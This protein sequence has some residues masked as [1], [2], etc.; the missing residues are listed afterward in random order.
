MTLALTPVPVTDAAAPA[1]ARELAA[2]V[3]ARG[4]GNTP[5]HILERARA[6]LLYGLG[7]ATLTAREPY[8]AIAEAA[9][10]AGEPA[11][12]GVCGATVWR[13]G[14][15]HG[16]S[17]AA[18]CNTVLM[19]SRCQEDTSGSAHIG[20]VVI[21]VALALIEAGFARLEDLLPA[22]VAGYEASGAVQRAIGRA[23]TARGF[24]ASPLYGTLAGAA[25]AARLLGLDIDGT[26]AAL[27]NAAAFAGG[28]LQSIGDGTDEWRY[29]MAGATRRALEAAFLARA[30]SRASP[31]SL[32]GA[33]G[34]A[35]AFAD[36]PL[37]APLRPGAPWVLP[38]V[39]FKPYPVCN[40]NQTA[41]LLAARLHRTVDLARV[42]RVHMRINGFVERGMLERG[43]FTSVAGTLMSTYF[44]CAAALVHGTVTRPML[45]RF[46]DPLIARWIG[47][48]EITPDDGVP[49]PSAQA[50]VEFDDGSTRRFD[51]RKVFADYALPRAEVQR[52]L[53]RL[54][55]EQ[56][57]PADG[58]GVSAIAAFADDPSPETMRR[59]LAALADAP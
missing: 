17:V 11:A 22:L 20:I 57:P 35:A 19:H 16:V 50:T 23:S 14:R 37:P 25:T 24:R 7:I 18:A 56:E 46:D 36:M 28:T 3:A 10:C 59:A 58:A 21:P 27:A 26:E 43:G 12:T 48:L 51:E 41:T 38:E 44:A 6:C 49:Y 53:E 30:G 55:R 39:A 1:A 47:K 54:A 45:D 34:F 2:F 15:R 40:R 33:R 31:R 8:P 42:R 52:L 32:D 13:S 5:S 4:H 9:L 29:Q